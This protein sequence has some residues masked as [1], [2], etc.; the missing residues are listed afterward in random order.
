MY[1]PVFHD[2][3]KRIHL[4]NKQ[5]FTYISIDRDVESKIKA[6]GDGVITKLLMQLLSYRSFAA[7]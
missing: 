5:I 4:L 6:A 7:Q 2:K 3:A 1:C